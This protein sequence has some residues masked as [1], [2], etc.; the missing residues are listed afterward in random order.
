MFSAFDP[1]A[2]V[3]PGAP[4]MVSARLNATGDSATL[5]WQAPDN[6][7]ATITAY[8]VYRKAASQSSFTLIATTPVTNY[9]DGTLTPPGTQY[10]YHV[11]AIN[12]AGESPYCS[13]AS[14]VFVPTPPTPPS[15]V[16]PGVLTSNDINQSGGDNDSGQNTPPD[17]RVNIRQLFIAEPCFG[18]GVNKLVFTMQLA[19]SPTNTSAPPSSQWYIV[20]NRQQ[21]DANFDRWYVAMKSNANGVLSYEYGKFGVELDP[22]NPNPNANMPVRLGNADTFPVRIR[23]QTCRCVWATL[24][25]A[26]RTSPRAW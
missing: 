14:P 20:W 2:F 5:N 25:P 1:P 24:T 23:T 26:P 17:P 11:T 10:Q 4:V 16:I 7:G 8:N 13:N 9:T 6:G 19:P 12:S 3:V 15:C 18:P 22:T 21:P